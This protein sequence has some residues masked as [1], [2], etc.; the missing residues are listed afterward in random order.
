MKFGALHMAWFFLLL[1]LLVIFYRWAFRKK[2][3]L[4]RRFA[5]PGLWKRIMVGLS[6][7]KQRLRP[8]LTV[9][10]VGL[11]AF[12]L[13]E[14]RWGYHWE[15][16][17][18]RGVDLLV[19]V[20][21]SRSM[22]AGD[23]KPSRLA[24]ARRDVEDLLGLVRG[25]RIGLI[26]FAGR[27]FVL[28]PLTLDYGALRIFINDLSVTTIPRGGSNIGAAIEKAIGTF[29]PGP[30]KHKALLLITDGENL[31]GDYEAAAQRAKQ[32]GV[33]IFTIGMGKEEGTPI[34]LTD[35]R[36][37]HYLKDREGNI[38]VSRLNE[39]ALEKIALLTGGAYH[40]A[41]PRGREVEL[42]YDRIAKMDKKELEESRK[43]V[44]EHRFQWP[45]LLA[46]A[47]LF[48]ESILGEKKGAFTGLFSKSVGRK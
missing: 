42:I 9:F 7:G 10:A 36:G 32:E 38:V 47:L 45:L 11:L 17:H 23:I 29:E 44:Y 28:C 21:T 1:P 30:G 26:A 16:I 14:P 15:D 24:R 46:L 39:P 6:A 37:S 19:A 34:T 43:K 35:D 25:D 31:E 27:A 20:D 12:S 4:Q 3:K 8:I 40:R 13:L 48:L 41:T 18:R 5:D 2:E 33:R 22:L